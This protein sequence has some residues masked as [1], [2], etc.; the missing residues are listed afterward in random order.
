[1]SQTFRR[2][3]EDLVLKK[4]ET[5]ASHVTDVL[6]VSTFTLHEDVNYLIS[7]TFI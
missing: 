6:K 1:M 5:K 2:L 3:V 7:Q 4:L